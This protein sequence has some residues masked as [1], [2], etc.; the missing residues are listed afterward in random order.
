MKKEFFC[1]AFI[2]FL[3]SCGDKDNPTIHSVDT[4]TAVPAAIT[5]LAADAKKDSNNT[6]L[7]M[8]LVNAYDSLGMYKNAITV[9]DK[10]ITTDSLNYDFWLRRGQLSKLSNDTP[11]ATR[12]FKYAA[13]V[14]PSPIALMEL[15]NMYA[16][17]RNPLALSVSQQLMKNNPGGDY[18]A[19]AYFFAG[20]YYSKTGDTKNAI[21]FF[22]KSI[23]QDIGFTDAYVE[24][25][26]LLYSN[27]NFAEALK[28]FEGL[29]TVNI[30]S[31][32]G[33]YWCARCKEALNDKQKAIELYEKALLLDKNIKEAADAL[34]RLK[35]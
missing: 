2:V 34:V 14:Y 27:K 13:R 29:I 21:D 22:N 17:T 18:N 35:K 8:N 12:S 7:Q 9:L 28:V 5:K 10:L 24:K 30:T 31:A 4:E 16:E 19:K 33:Y 26:Y 23:A 1:I 15:A 20:V 3:F 6:G 25:G 32:D 11:A